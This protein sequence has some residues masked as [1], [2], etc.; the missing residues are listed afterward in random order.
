MTLLLLSATC[1]YL[2]V[3]VFNRS[4]FRHFRGSILAHCSECSQTT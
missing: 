3:D 1:A 4:P 2:I